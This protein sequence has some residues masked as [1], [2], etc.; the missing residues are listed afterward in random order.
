MKVVSD[1][2][3]LKNIL[4]SNV[5]VRPNYYTKIGLHYVGGKHTK[6]KSLLARSCRKVDLIICSLK[7]SILEIGS[8][9]MYIRVLHEKCRIQQL[10]NWC[11]C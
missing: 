7:M 2:N 3:V 8:Q 9:C 6:K 11:Q 5:T 4:I 10:R 1:E